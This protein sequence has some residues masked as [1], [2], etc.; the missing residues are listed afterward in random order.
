MLMT[1]T[2]IEA[3]ID[4]YIAW[5]LADDPTRASFQGAE[6]YDDLMPDLSAAG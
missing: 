1:V 6:G 2:A 4:E 5:V 3:L